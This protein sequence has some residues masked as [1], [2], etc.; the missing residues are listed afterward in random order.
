MDT[1]EKAAEG[2]GRPVQLAIRLGRLALSRRLAR[3][4]ELLFVTRLGRVKWVG[5]VRTAA[6]HVKNE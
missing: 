2:H 1:Q 5:V 4:S 6:R 3:G